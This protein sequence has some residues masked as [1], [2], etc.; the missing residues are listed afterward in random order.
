MLNLFGLE[1]KYFFR[2]TTPPESMVEGVEEKRAINYMSPSAADLLPSLERVM[3]VYVITVG[4][5]VFFAPGSHTHFFTL[6]Y[7]KYSCDEL[8]RVECLN[9]SDLG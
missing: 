7:L 5:R 9:L 2:I 1:K 6:S 4:G 8:V 3:A